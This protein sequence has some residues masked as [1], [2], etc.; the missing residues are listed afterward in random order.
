MLYGGPIGLVSAMAN[1][2]AEAVSGSDLG[3]SM[4]ASILGSDDG[5]TAP[6]LAAGTAEPPLGASLTAESGPA[7]APEGGARVAAPPRPPVP[8][9]SEPV[10]DTA[11]SPQATDAGKTGLLTGNAALNALAADLAG[12]SPAAG[13]TEAAP[14]EAE[15]KAS[16]DVPVPHQL[17]AAQGRQ[18][19]IPLR[20]RDW[21]AGGITRQPKP[22]PLATPGLAATAGGPS[23]LSAGQNQTLQALS[24]P[25]GQFPSPVA[26]EL[27]ATGPDGSAFAGRMLEALDKYSAM[28]GQSRAPGRV[29]TVE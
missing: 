15:K 3:A 19:A 22:A 2:I 20:E 29:V 6:S 28:M 25:S 27:L 1:T 23:A 8:V 12:A 13:D 21:R 5:E 9:A 17:S 26:P 4:L 14:S 16:P 18:R 10:S 24:A 7:V 11:V